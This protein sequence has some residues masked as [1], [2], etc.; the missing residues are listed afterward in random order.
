MPEVKL[1]DTTLRD[2][3]QH[4]GISYSV[5]DKLK[6]ARKLDELGIHVI[7][8]GWPGANARDTEFFQRMRGVKLQH[9]VLAAFGSTRRAKSTA[10]NDATLKALLEA[11]T[12]MITIVGKSHDLHVTK[13]LETTLDENIAMIRDSV[14]YLRSKGRRVVLDAEHFFDGFKAN[15]EYAVACVKAAAEAGAECV[16]LCDTNGGTLPNEVRDIVSAVRRATN[17]ELGIHAH[18]DA[19]LAV[20]NS[21]TALQT[22]VV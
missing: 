4:E 11:E 5:E 20:A 10:E 13:V 2:G 19:E 9:A 7:E 21:L 8:G 6:I 3:A 15:P 12:P 16:A 17:V 22:G 18:N 14:S 1:Y